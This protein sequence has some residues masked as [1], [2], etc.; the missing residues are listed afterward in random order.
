MAWN[1]LAVFDTIDNVID[2]AS[3]AVEDTDRLNELKAAAEELRQSVYMRELETKTVPWVDALHKMGR[4]LMGYANLG[5]GVYL[6]SNH[7]E[8]NAMALAAIVA[9]SSIYTYI[10]GKGK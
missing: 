3:E 8:I 5:A 7:P 2:L 4:Q 10:K 6:L 1:P 9:P